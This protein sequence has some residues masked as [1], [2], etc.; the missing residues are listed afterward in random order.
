MS[1]DILDAVKFGN[2]RKVEDYINNKGNVNA[3]DTDGS[4]LLIIAAKRGWFGIGKD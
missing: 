2:Q 1:R 3:K 4:T